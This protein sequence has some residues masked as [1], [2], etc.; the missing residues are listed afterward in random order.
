MQ[1]PTLEELS[2]PTARLLS[3]ALRAA[4]HRSRTHTVAS[5]P[6]EVVDRRPV[7]IIAGTFGRM[8]GR[9]PNLKRS[10]I[11]IRLSNT[12]TSEYFDIC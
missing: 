1:A 8:K 9:R 2:G 6:L 3:L 4:D 11:R 12:L 7:A 5:D 10:Q